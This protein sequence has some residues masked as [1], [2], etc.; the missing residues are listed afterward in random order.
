MF[1]CPKKPMTTLDNILDFT[2]GKRFYRFGNADGKFWIV[3]ARGMRTALNLYQPSG[4]KGKM[5]K[6]LLPCLHWIAPVR[7]VIK[8]QTVNCRLNSELHSLLCRVFNVKEIEFAIFEGTPS[9]HQKIT[10]QL[11][12]GN[13]ILGYCKLSTNNDIKELFGKEYRT[14]DRLCK[15]GVTGV[16]KALHCGT[17]SNGMHVF[18]QSTEKQASSKIIHEWGAL[19]EEFLAQLHEKT[20][21]VLLFEESNYYTTLSTLEQHLGWLPQEIDHQAV[22]NAINA[23]KEKYCGKKVVFCACHC[24]FTP[25]NM[26]ANGNELFVFDFEYAAMSYPAGLDRYHF[27]TQTAVFEKH[28]GIDEISA[29]ME[30]DAGRWI[31]KE[32]YAMYLLDVI[33][34]F[35]MRENGKVTGGAAAPFALWGKLLE[36]VITSQ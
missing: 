15:S 10:M 3:P 4:R 32:L 36:F 5:V 8:A 20:K 12:Q 28:W 14:L 23:I 24:D 21:A 2:G 26:F 6:R 22:G 33:S 16:P 19:Q 30:S 27:F 13:R 31:D 9:V 35:T 1:F 29:Y 18:V 25:W 34:R 17:L 7:K 11:S